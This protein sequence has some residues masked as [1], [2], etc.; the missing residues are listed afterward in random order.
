MEVV[1]LCAGAGGA[2]NR[3]PEGLKQALVGQLRELHDG[4]AVTSVALALR[5]PVAAGRH[6]KLAFC[7]AHGRVALDVARAGADEGTEKAGFAA[8]RL[9]QPPA[10][11]YATRRLSCPPPPSPDASAT[12]NGSCPPPSPPPPPLPPPP[13]IKVQTGATVFLEPMFRSNLFL[14]L[15]GAP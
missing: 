12:T 13:F 9:H 15:G 14:S 6:D 2:G 7:A 1:C 3:A 11:A 10:A 5:A 8:R 4:Q